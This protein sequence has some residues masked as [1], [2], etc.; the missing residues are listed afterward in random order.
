M[1]VALVLTATFGDGGI[2]LAQDMNIS[3]SRLRI[4]AADGT[5]CPRGLPGNSGDNPQ[6]QDFC[7]D[8]DSWR[9]LMSD[10]A[11][12]VVSMPSVARTTGYSGFRVMVESSV[13]GIDA[14]SRR[15]Q[16]GTEGGAGSGQAFCDGSTGLGCNPN[17]S[18][19]LSWLK[20]GAHKGLPFGFE[21]GGTFGHLFNTDLFAWGLELKWALLE[22]LDTGGG[23]LPD[24]ALRGTVQSVVGDDEFNLVVPTLDLL[25]SK[26]LTVADAAVIMPFLAGQLAWTI[27][28]SE[29]VDLTP[30]VNAVEECVPSTVA[31][32]TS[33]TRDINSAPLPDG[34]YPG[35]DFNNNATFDGVRSMRARLALGAE[36]R[37]R[38][39][40]VRLG[41]AF[42]LL[43]PADLSDEIPDEVSRQWTASVSAGAAF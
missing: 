42:D 31:A 27:A 17:P 30:D 21:V 9:G 4:S 33:C 41:F 36:G 38:V 34:R 10:L 15:W 5:S 16:L 14:G 20:V 28:D 19:L 1:A 2:S 40:V 35:Q 6:L 25:V 18:S 8:N 29:V 43:G 39:L 22:G 3:L 26:P 23:V 13:T 32:E 24:V 37:Y 12:S 7:P 11:G